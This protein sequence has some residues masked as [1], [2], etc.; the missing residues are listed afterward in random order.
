[1]MFL[2]LYSMPLPFAV[3]MLTDSLWPVHVQAIVYGVPHVSVC[4]NWS[5]PVNGV[6]VAVLRLAQPA[7]LLISSASGCPARSSARHCRRLLA[8]W[9]QG[10]PTR[11]AL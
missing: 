7:A 8:G 3:V 9:G 4:V 6:T 2:A 5:K 10:S 1:M 11:P